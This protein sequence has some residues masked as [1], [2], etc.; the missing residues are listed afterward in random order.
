[1]NW[2]VNPKV[3]EA[4]RDAFYLSFKNVEATGKRFLLAICMS[5]PEKPHVNGT[6]IIT[7]IEAAAAMA[8]VTLRSEKSCDI[9]AFSGKQ[10]TEHP[11]FSISPQDDLNVVL[12]KCSKLPCDK[13]NIAAPIIHAFENK[14]MYDVFVVYTDSVNEDGSVHPS[15]AL[16]LY[17][18]GSTIKNARLI[19]CGLASNR[20]SIADPNDPLMMD[21]VGFDSNTPKAIHQFVTGNF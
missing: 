12:D 21:I 9:V 4:L 8:L 16:E 13:I 11:N 18:Q 1:M 2:Q 3:R 19:V 10:S 20:F 5:D 7:A 6:P 14:K 15:R 17:R